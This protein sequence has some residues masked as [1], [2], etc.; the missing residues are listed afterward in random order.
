MFV[1]LSLRVELVCVVCQG[2]DGIPGSQGVVGQDGIPGR[3]GDTGSTGADGPPVSND[4]ALHS[5]AILSQSMRACT[6]LPQQ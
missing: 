6:E 5:L 1:N 3:T 4:T 2:R